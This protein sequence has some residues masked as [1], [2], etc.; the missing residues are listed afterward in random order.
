MYYEAFSIAETL[1][2]NGNIDLC[3]IEHETMLQSRFVWYDSLLLDIL[4]NNPEYGKSI[5]I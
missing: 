5:F 3:N 2:K 1:K 4:K